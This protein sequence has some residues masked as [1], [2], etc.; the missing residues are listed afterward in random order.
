LDIYTQLKITFKY[1]ILFLILFVV[2]L[3]YSQTPPV[4]TFDS[5]V[6]AYYGNNNT[7]FS[8]NH[9]TTT[10]SNRI[11][12]VFVST[13]NRGGIASGITSV[14][15][16]GTAMTLLASSTS[17]AAFKSYLY[18]I[19]NPT[20]GTNSIVVTP[21]ERTNTFA[22]G[23]T[24]YYNVKQETPIFISSGGYANSANG[25][26][27]TPYVNDVL[28]GFC[29]SDDNTNGVG[30]GQTI[31]Y[32]VGSASKVYVNLSS[33]TSTGTSASF[34]ITLASQSSDYGLILAR[35]TPLGATVLPVTLSS[36]EQ[37][38]KD[39]YT[40]LNWTT[41]SEL[42]NDYFT[43][44]KS[45]DAIN[46]LSIGQVEG[47]GNSN[48]PNNYHFIDEEIN[49][50]ST[51]YRLKQTD[52]NGKT[53]TFQPILST[54]FENNGTFCYPNP[55][56]NQTFIKSDINFTEASI[57]SLDGR[58]IDKTDLIKSNNSIDFSLLSS[59][60]YLV[61]LSCPQRQSTFIKITKE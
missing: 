21:V 46:Y 9:T 6:S 55:V 24:T 53:E 44:E 49:L 61:L 31:V 32:N 54:C 60:M 7:T 1:I 20:S 58:I 26:I 28:L 40:A 5:Q 8:W 37:T 36:F 51:Y 25:T 39:N 12:L 56:N 30:T 17:Q 45:E 2:N 4:V 48:E 11:V 15:Y 41:S 16:G 18:F 33:K 19:L 22:A 3:S 35:L 47:N 27:E 52:F 43:I 38:C 14:T 29:G 13:A 57:Y 50:K 42:N 23:S 10:S 34:L 59:G